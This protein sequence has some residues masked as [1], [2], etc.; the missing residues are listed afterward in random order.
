MFAE[1]NIWRLTFETVVAEQIPKIRLFKEFLFGKTL[2]I[3]PL[4]ECL[5]KKLKHLTKLL[6]LHF[7]LS[8]AL[9]FSF[10]SLSFVFFFW[11]LVYFSSLLLSLSLSSLSLCL[12]F[13]ISL[14]SFSLLPSLSFSS[15]L[16]LFH[17]PAIFC[18]LLPFRTLLLFCTLLLV[19]VSAFFV[20]LIERIRFFQ[21]IGFVLPARRICS[22]N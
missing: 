2:D 12:L 16:L 3:S 19:C 9:P 11:C 7:R 18:R 4:K 21:S 20:F 13:I 5:L 22:S 6:S 10:R 15:A 14:F 1:K 17:A 8:L